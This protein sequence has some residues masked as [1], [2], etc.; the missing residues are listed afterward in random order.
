MSLPATE[1]TQHKKRGVTLAVI[2]VFL[3]STSPVF[4]RW[5]APLSAYEITAW[6]VL[7]ATLSVGALAL[8]Q[9]NRPKLKK[10]HFLKF[11]FFGLITALHFL[12]YIASLKFTTIAHS[13]TIVYTAPI[14]VALFSMFFLKESLSGRKWLG[15][16]VV[17]VGIGVLAGFEPAMTPRMLLGDALALAS[18]V[19]FGVY[20]IAG[21]SQRSVYPLLTYAFFVYLLATLWLAPVA[22]VTFTPQGYGLKQIL[23]LIALGVLPLGIGHT[24]YNAAVRN[25]NATYAN[26]VATQEVT[27]GVLLGILFLHEIPGPTSIVGVLITFAGILIVLL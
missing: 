9:G 5:A 24:L 17:V 18:A 3:F 4:I 2:A 20:S 25:M 22:A 13:L 6:R 16:A 26:L 1:H 7:I 23:S 19:T 27:G 14:F 8:Y 11:V 12:S 15:I 21:R 10:G